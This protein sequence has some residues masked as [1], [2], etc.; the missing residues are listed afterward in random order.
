MSRFVLVPVPATEAMVDAG[1]AA[2][3][4]E[5]LRWNDLNADEVWAA[6]VGAA[7]GPFSMG[8]SMISV[9]ELI[10]CLKLLPQDLEVQTCTIERALDHLVE[11]NLETHETEVSARHYGPRIFT[12]QIDLD[13]WKERPL[14]LVGDVQF[15]ETDRILAGLA[16]DK[17]AKQGGGK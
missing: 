2:A 5:D 6:M 4:K 8:G 15:T 10:D 14:P 9:A 13:S 3:C 17:L 16:R 12:A 1:N 7:A 11:S